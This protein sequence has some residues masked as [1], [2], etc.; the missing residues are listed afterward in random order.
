MIHP[1]GNVQTQQIAIMKGPCK[2]CKNIFLGCDCECFKHMLIL[3]KRGEAQT[4][5]PTIISITV[6]TTAAITST[7]SVPR[8]IRKNIHT[9]S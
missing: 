4:C 9:F 2:N 6:V 7:P 3:T 5:R 1:Y 8:D